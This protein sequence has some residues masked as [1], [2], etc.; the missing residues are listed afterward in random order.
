MV[1]IIFKSLITFFSVYGFVNLIKDL[2]KFFSGEKQENLRNK[3]IVIKVRNSAETLEGAVRSVIL[4]SLKYTYNA[5]VP[6]ILIVDMGSDD[7]TRQ[8]AGKLCED[9]PFVYYTT[10]ELYNKVKGK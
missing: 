10:E 5:S 9:Y 7:E 3:I 1:N 6:D 2:F 8:I 4:S